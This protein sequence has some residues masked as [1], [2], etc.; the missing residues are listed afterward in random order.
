MRFSPFNIILL[1]AFFAVVTPQVGDAVAQSRLRSTEVSDPSL[2]RVNERTQVG[3]VSF[4]FAGASLF[5]DETLQGQLFTFGP[6]L[7]DRILRRFSF[8]WFIDEKTY[9][10]DP[11]ELHKDAIRL[12]R[13]IQRNGYP[14]VTVDYLGTTLDTNANVIDVAFDIDPGVPTILRELNVRSMSGEALETV[15]PADLQPQWQR[16]VRLYESSLGKRYTELTRIRLQDQLSTWLQNHAYAFNEIASTVAIDSTTFEVSITYEA[17]LGP[18]AVYDTVLVEGAVSVD[19]RVVRRELPFRRGDPFNFSELKRGQQEIFALNMF[20]LALVEVPPQP[21]DSTVTVRVRV[22]E[23]DLRYVQSRLGFA[24]EEGL[25]GE[26]SWRNRNFLGNARQV[27]LTAHGQPGTLAQPS[28]GE[29]TQLAGASIMVRQPYIYSTRLSGTVGPFVNYENNPNKELSYVDFGATMGLVF[30]VLPFR[31]ISI[32]QRVSR[33]VPV[34]TSDLAQEKSLFD[35]AVISLAG[36]IG[37]LDNYIVPTRGTMIR[38]SVE[39]AGSF[40]ASGVEYRKVAIETIRYQPLVPGWSVVF[41]LFGG[42]LWPYGG[43]TDQEDPN[44]EFRFDRI[45]FEAGGSGDVRGWGPGLLGPKEPRATIDT[46]GLSTGIIPNVSNFVYE[47]LGG[48]AKLVGNVEVRGPLPGL[49]PAWGFNAFVDGGQLSATGQLSGDAF[50]FSAGGGLRYE[51]PVGFLKVDVGY[52]LNPDPIDIQDPVKRL[53]YL[54]GYSATAPPA[55]Q[56]RRF[57]VHVSIGQSL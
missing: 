8:L 28:N 18:P 33:A 50:R 54:E 43:S 25:T 29:P 48:L 5:D 24:R 38:P 32:S 1:L 37:R 49:P 41:R 15:L 47:P 39:L 42:R 13:Y 16:Q 57:R 27:S 11:V 31:T 56:S 35:Q 21:E 51:T 23:A 17:R 4:S 44:I 19:P 40:F 46:T 55:E 10:F 36:N 20:R 9:P 3:D 7:G 53:L 45:R 12:E 52:M 6:S 14:K 2:L 30:D 34:G 22:R 26:V